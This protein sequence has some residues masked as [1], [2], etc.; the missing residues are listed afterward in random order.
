[1]FWVLWQLTR[2][3]SMPAASNTKDC[4]RECVGKKVVGVLFDAIPAGRRDIASGT[5]TLVFKDGTGLTISSNGSWW[6]D[7]ANEV[8]RATEVIRT[9]LMRTKDDIEDVIKTE[10]AI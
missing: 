3:H 5:K 9:E 1:M 8:K 10:A 6:L 7:S 2:E 4:F